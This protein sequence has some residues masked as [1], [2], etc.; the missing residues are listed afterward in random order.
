MPNNLVLKCYLAGSI[1]GLTYSE[2]TTWRNEASLVLIKMGIE[3][4]DPMRFDHLI[5]DVNS[6][7]KIDDSKVKTVGRPFIRGKCY[8]DLD[9]SDMVLCNFKDVGNKACIGTLMEL[10]YA[11]SQNKLIYGFN[12]VDD[13][14]EHP[15]LIDVIKCSTQKKAI[16]RIW[17]KYKHFLF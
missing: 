15:F 11:Y 3:P 13:Y 10:G 12:L 16:S 14:K 6:P 1:N 17:D 5:L 7:D 8:D 4:I 2:A 9:R